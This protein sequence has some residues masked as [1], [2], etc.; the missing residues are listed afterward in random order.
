[1]KKAFK[2][3]R[4]SIIVVTDNGWGDTGKGKIVDVLS[5]S[6]DMAIR[7]N[8]GPNAGHTVKTDQGTFVFHGLPSGILHKSVLNILSTG[9]VVNP[10]SLAKEITT[11]Q[12]QG[13]A[14]TPKNFLIEKTAHMIMPWHTKRDSL[15]EKARGKISIGTTGQG[16]GPTYADRALRQGL[17]A[18]DLLLRNFEEVFLEE[19]SWQEKLIS[20]MDNNSKKHFDKKKLL[21]DLKKAQSILK[22][23][24]SNVLPIIHLYQKSGKTIIGEAGQG[25]LLDLDLGGYPFVTSSNPGVAG[26]LKATGI[27]YKKI[28]KVYGVTK[29][30]TTRVG[31]GPMPT[32]LSGKIGEYLQ[33]KGN[34]VG[35]TTGRKRRC[36]WFDAVAMKK[37]LQ[38]VGADEIVLTK[39]DILDELSEI[40]ICVAYDFGGKR[41]KELPDTDPLFMQKAKP[42]YETLAGWKANTSGVTSFADLPKNARNY[43]LFI[44]KLL[45]VPISIISTGPKRDETIF[46]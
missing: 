33:T 7:Y 10:L 5:S 41:Y 27:H 46:R 16:I 24:V 9:V 40:K 26:F 25:A 21:S 42:I 22:P 32:E 8:G 45:G 28:T 19:L 23:F 6:A 1:M 15:V 11:A 14:I 12:K 44:E 18:G 29:A 2:L 34:E 20:V 17:R 43:I 39:S 30:Y 36:G 31:Q 13:V 38:I 37:G 35:A 3:K 4:G